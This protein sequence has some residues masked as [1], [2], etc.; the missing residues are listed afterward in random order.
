VNGLNGY[1]CRL[2]KVRS[3]PESGL[4]VGLVDTI[5]IIIISILE[6]AVISGKV[7]A[8]KLFI[9]ILTAFFFP[10]VVPFRRVGES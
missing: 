6:T 8:L 5:I 10:S 4:S 2:S 1:F 3:S 9:I 7:K